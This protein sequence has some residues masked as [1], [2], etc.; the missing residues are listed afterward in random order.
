MVITVIG[1][2]NLLFFEA[3]SNCST[4]ILLVVDLERTL[5]LGL[6]AFLFATDALRDILADIGR[7]LDLF[8]L[9]FWRRILSDSDRKVGVLKD[10][11]GTAGADDG[12]IRTDFLWTSD[13]E[14]DRIKRI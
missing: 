3:I 10:N 1:L 14:L 7:D 9:I 2:D 5:N 12:R 11:V 4:D 13:V 6:C 8:G